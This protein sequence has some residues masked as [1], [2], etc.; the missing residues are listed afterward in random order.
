MKKYSMIIALL[1]IGLA[2][3]AT[4]A[5]ACCDGGPCCD[6]NPPCCD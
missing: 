1:F 2:G 6:D 3:A 5:G 4:A